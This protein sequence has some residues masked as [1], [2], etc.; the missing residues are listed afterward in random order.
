MVTL[1]AAALVVS[2]FT[3]STAQMAPVQG[4]MLNWVLEGNYRVTYDCLFGDKTTKSETVEQVKRIEFHP[5]YIVT[6]D[7]NDA[8]RVVPIY[9]IKQFK[10]EPS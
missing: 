3:T 4:K 1:I 7:Q 5:E 9:T 10:W 2:T 8:G 6:V